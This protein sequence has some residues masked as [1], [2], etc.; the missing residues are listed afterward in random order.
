MRRII[1]SHILLVGLCLGLLFAYGCWGDQ[2]APAEGDL[3]AEAFEPQFAALTADSMASPHREG[4]CWS[5]TRGA[6]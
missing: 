2:R 6:V 3:A 1:P 4:D 5:R